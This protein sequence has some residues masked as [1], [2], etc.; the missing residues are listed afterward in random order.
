MFKII[1]KFYKN[2]KSLLFQDILDFYN[3]HGYCI[4][5]YLYGANMVKQDLLGEGR[6]HN[7]VLKDVCYQLNFKSILL[8]S[9]FL[10]PDG[11]AIRTMR[12]IGK[13]FK[14]FDGPSMIPN[15]NGTDFLPYFID[16]L[17]SRY[18]S[19]H[20]YIYFLTVYDENIGNPKW[21]LKSRCEK[22][23]YERF[24]IDKDHVR[25]YEIDYHDEN[26]ADWKGRIDIEDTI[27]NV[28]KDSYHIFLNFRGTPYQE[29][30]TYLNKDFIKKNNLILF[31]QGGTVDF[32][33]G[34]E[35]RAPYWVRKLR[36]ESI[37]RL[38]QH[39]KKNW[40]KFL[41]SFKMIWL[42][43]KKVVLWLK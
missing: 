28:N 39:P 12:K 24:D 14:K 22:Y 3:K 41:V 8:D 36:L 43:I 30:W 35:T 10:L 23:V 31:N 42:I 33:V 4:V 32:W 18:G 7:I 11:A 16:K 5:N 6:K 20:I 15:L 19:D 25:W 21:Y 2:S 27:N 26:Y 1:D 9:D 29:I 37:W 40:K 17:I 34:K 38:L 13:I